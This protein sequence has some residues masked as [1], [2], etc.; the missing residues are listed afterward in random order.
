MFEIRINGV[1]YTRWESASVSRSIDNSSGQFNFSTSDLSPKEFP[2]K[3]GDPVVVLVGGVAKCTG[4]V[5]Q[6]NA[7]GDSTSH[8]I[9]V[10]G[11][12]NTSDLID[13][14]TPASVR[15]IEGPISLQKICTDVI[16]ALGANIQVDDVSGV[17]NVFIST[18]LQASENGDK[19]MEFLQSY[20]RKKQVFLIPSGDGRLLIFRPGAELATSPILHQ[21]GND[22]N[23]VK[24]WNL[25]QKQDGR[26]NKYICRSQ[27]NI[28]FDEGADYGPDGMNRKGEVVDPNIRQGRTLEI[29]AEESM[30]DDQC[31]ERAKEEA[32]IRRARSTEYSVVVV[33][34]QQVDGKVWDIGQRTTV[35]DDI[36]GINGSFIIRSVEYTIELGQGE[37]TKIVFAPIDAYKVQAATTKTD[38]RKSNEGRKYT[39]PF[40]PRQERFQR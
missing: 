34:N 1:P 29:N 6:I 37:Q 20:S 18:E 19:C 31:L 13:S 23:N 27:D 35:K 21:L 11:R 24:S 3:R 16:T 5:D 8:T 30:N 40:P 15:V 7:S 32:N 4:F 17:A 36:A 33:G 14:S 22:Q 10:S 9:T 38:A 28:G 2:I 26:Y 39:R 12:D 25:S